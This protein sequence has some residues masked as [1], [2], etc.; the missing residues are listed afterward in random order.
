M[1]SIKLSVT[2]RA[3]LVRKYDA[4]ALAKIDTAV[5]KW[6]AADAAR[7]IKTVHVAIDDA[8]KM[9][10]LGVKAL[11]GNATPRKVKRAIDALWKK[12]SPDYLVLFGADDVVPYFVVDNPSY[13]PNGDDDKDVATD[14]P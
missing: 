1:E 7:D 8:T 3:N 10:A 11:K 6:I 9:A 4:G 13:D 12:L 5:A 2:V 14:N